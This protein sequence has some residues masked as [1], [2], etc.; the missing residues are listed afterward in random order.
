MKQAMVD[1]L[2]VSEVIV[3]AAA[4]A[5]YR[6]E[7]TM[8]AKVKKEDAGSEVV[9]RLTQTP[10]VLAHLCRLRSGRRPLIVGFAAETAG[11]AQ[12]LH[13]L[14][15]AKMARKG[16]DL[17]VAND[18]GADA[19]FG[20]QENAVMILAPDGSTEQVPRASKEAIADA[21][22]DHVVRGLVRP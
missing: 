5:D 20:S 4:V 22:W 9:L 7:H 6:P 11:S 14:A 21:V 12:E 10:D 19:V 8:T 15:A 18:V 17:L 13:R 3:M 1:L 2:P 16:C